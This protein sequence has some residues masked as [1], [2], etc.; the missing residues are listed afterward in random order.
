MLVGAHWASCFQARCARWV[1]A[2]N[3]IPVPDVDGAVQP[4][5]QPACRGRSVLKAHAR[6]LDAPSAA[7]ETPI[8]T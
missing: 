8:P 2:I 4:V 3:V 7:G 6:R 1:R 5:G